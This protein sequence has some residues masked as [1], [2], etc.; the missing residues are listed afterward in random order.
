MIYN[1]KSKEELFMDI[2]YNLFKRTS[3]DYEKLLK[4]GFK[5][6]DDKYIY[7]KKFINGDL[8]A[9]ITIVDNYVTGKVIDLETNDEYFAIKT[10]MNGSFVSKVRDEYLSILFDIKEKCFE[11]KLFIT[12]QANRIANFIMKKYQV[13]PEFLWENSSGHGVFRNKVNNKWFGII[14]NVDG[15]KF[16]NKSGEVEVLNIKLDKLKIQDL[17]NKKGYFPAYHMNKKSWISIILDEYLD[18][19]TIIKLVSE[20]YDQVNK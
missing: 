10:I 19:E 20:S 11:N 7:E 13:E 3:V 8:K 12:D 1:K 15:M 9:I 17:L 16:E 18:D 4:Y 14:M 2:E 6:N 5:K